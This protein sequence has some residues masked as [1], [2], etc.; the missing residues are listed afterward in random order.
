MPC[1]MRFHDGYEWEGTLQKVRAMLDSSWIVRLAVIL[2][3]QVSSVRR[4]GCQTD[5]GVDGRITRKVL[6]RREPRWR[7]GKMHAVKVFDFL[8][9][10]DPA[11]QYRQRVIGLARSWPT[12]A[13]MISLR[14]CMH[15]TVTMGQLLQSLS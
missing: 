9:L 12:F 8:V 3:W 7:E 10:D 4:S 2:S 11:V 5:N 6:S 14:I 15:W 13:L 1:I